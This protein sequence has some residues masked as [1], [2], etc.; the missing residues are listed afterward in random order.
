VNDLFIGKGTD[1]L[2]IDHIGRGKGD[3]RGHSS[4]I[5]CKRPRFFGINEKT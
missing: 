1:R 3:G 5:K 2:P 4:R